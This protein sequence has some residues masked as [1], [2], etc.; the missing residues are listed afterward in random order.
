M[1]KYERPIRNWNEVPL[2]FDVYFA[3]RLLGM[4]Y[5][6]L[7]RMIKRGDFPAKK[8]GGEWRVNKSDVMEILGCRPNDRIP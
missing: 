1:T 5:D 8:I 6:K 4:S 2:A 3:A 7:R